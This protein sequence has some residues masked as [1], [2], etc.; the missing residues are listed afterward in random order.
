MIKRQGQFG[1]GAGWHPAR[2]LLTRAVC[3]DW[4]SARRLPTCPTLL[5][6]GLAALAL[7]SAKADEWDK[8]GQQL[9]QDCSSLFSSFSVVKS[10]ATFLFHD[11]NP[12]RM[13][14]PSSVV[15]G[16]GTAIGAMYVQPLD[17]H[18][19][20][21]SN[22][23]VEGGSSLRAFWYGNA[24]ASFNHRKW[25]GDWNTAR[26]S[27]QLQI[28][29]HARGLPQM[30][31][32]GIGPDTARSNLTDFREHDYR[33]GVSVFNPLQSWL[34]AGGLAEFYLTKIGGDH[35][36]GVHSIDESYSETTAPGLGHQPGFAHYSVFL[37]PRG[38]W[39]RTR[40]DS[41]IAYDY[42]HDAGTGRYST[43]KFHAEYL[44]KIYPES[45]TESSGGGTGARKQVKY[46]S[47][48]Y[49]A[50][51]FTAASAPAGSVVPFY[52]EDTIGGSDI[53]GIPTLRGFQDYRFRGPDLFVIQTQ[54]ERRL[55]PPRPTGAK[56][57]TLRSVAGA[58]G[59]LAFYDAGQVALHASDLSFGNLRQSY[60][61][62]LTFWSGNKVWFRAYVGLGSGEGAHS[63][64]GV[65]DPSPQTPHL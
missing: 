51:R 56:S 29:S 39:T 11:G 33:A 23:T 24:V 54:Y 3:A 40:I 28:Y 59:I 64:F 5:I 27:F 20:T 52:L 21:G 48:L 35:N 1:C 55:L 43:R 22:L 15:P 49:I 60:G 61:F 37:Q 42:Y 38:E 16:G 50:G 6:L 41:R 4:Q 45:Q 31:F 2:G 8:E 34:A 26:D 14:I 47:V 10:C 13:S 25:G 62:G 19:W 9:S 12:V 53:N 57:S 46:D 18:N 32:Y 58:L 7:S 36:S 17:I 65:N 30:P 63:F 44:Q